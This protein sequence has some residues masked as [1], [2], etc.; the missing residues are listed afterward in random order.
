M[1]T[2]LVM[3]T[4]DLFSSSIQ[5]IPIKVSC[6]IKSMICSLPSLVEM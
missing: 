1:S 5:S 4:T 6:F 3:L 2:T